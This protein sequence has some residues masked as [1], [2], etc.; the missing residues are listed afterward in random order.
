MEPRSDRNWVFL[1][2]TQLMGAAR[3]L[4]WSSSPT[5]PTTYTKHDYDP[6]SDRFPIIHRVNLHPPR[7]IPATRFN[8]ER[9]A[10]PKVTHEVASLLKWTS[11]IQYPTQAKIDHAAGHL[12]DCIQQSLKKHVAV[13]LPSPYSKQW[14]TDKLKAARTKVN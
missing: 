13:S 2:S 4:T 10:W 8:W 3:S 14:W 1:L 7:N 5:L 12:T 6:D 9:T 11:P